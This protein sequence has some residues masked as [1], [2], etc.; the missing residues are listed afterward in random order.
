MKDINKEVINLWNSTDKK[1]LNNRHPFL[2]NDIGK[3]KMIFIGIN[4][5]FSEKGFIKSFKE[6]EDEPL[7]EDIARAFNKLKES[8]YDINNFF[9]YS[10]DSTFDMKLSLKV[11]EYT[12]EHYPYFNRFKEIAKSV[13][14][15]WD[16][17]DLFYLRETKQKNLA[18]Y[19]FKKKLELNIFGQAQFDITKKVVEKIE[20]KIIVVANALASNLF[21]NEYKIKFNET[22]GCYFTEINNQM[23]PTFLSSMLSGQRA[24]DNF[25]YERLIWHIKKVIVKLKL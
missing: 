21:K 24:L 13:D 19:V 2:L 18:K 17:I 11:E 14:M 15:E 16:S 6:L 22:Y 23:I 3:N 10:E 20:P 8:N 7:D 9:S 4:P 12:K 25:S 5:S 1:L